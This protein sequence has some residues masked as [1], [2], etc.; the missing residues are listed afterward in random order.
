MGFGLI[1]IFLKYEVAAQISIYDK[2]LMPKGNPTTV[3]LIK[4]AKKNQQIIE[5]FKFFY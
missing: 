5:M 3:S 2:L 1:V 4:P